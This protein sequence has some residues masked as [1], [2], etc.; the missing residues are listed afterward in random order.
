MAIGDQFEVLPGDTLATIFGDNTN[1]PVVV[2]GGANFTQADTVGLPT[3]SGAPQPTYYFNTT[4]GYW[5]QYQGATNT[6]GSPVN[7]NSAIIYPNTA[8]VVLVRNANPTAQLSLMGRVS[9]VALLQKVT[10][11]TSTYNSTQCA[12]DITLGQLSLGANWSANNIFTQADT[13]GVFPFGQSPQTFSVYYEDASQNWHLYP[14]TTN[15]VNST[16]IPAGS[17][18]TILK[19]SGVSGAG[20]FLTTSMPYSVSN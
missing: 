7:V 2:T 6:N 9:Q 5:A 10:G 8:A 17:V 15:T 11:R 18:L 19:R 4:Y 12:A 3:T 20:A 14:N 16:T 13:I 1:T